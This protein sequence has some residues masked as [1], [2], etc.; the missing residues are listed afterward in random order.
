MSFVNT[1]KIAKNTVLLYVRM[2]LLM[3]VSFYTSRVILATLGVDDYGLYNLIGGIITLFSFISGSLV[4]AMQRYF[5]VALGQHDEAKYHRVYVMG[6]NL[7]ILFSV[8]VLLVGETVGLWFVNNKLNVPEGRETAAFWVYQFSILTMIVHLLKTPDNASIIAHERMGFYAYLSIGEALL[9]LGI[10][11]FLQL[12]E[13]D[14]LILYVILYFAASVLINVAYKVYCNRSFT[15]CHYKWLWDS[16]LSKE[17]LSF[18]GWSL[19]TSGTRTVTMQ[20]ENVFLNQ[21]YSVSVNAARGVASQ[22][23][24]T[25]NTFV[26]NFVIAFRPQLIKSYAAGEMENH[27]SL[28]YRSSKFS[29]YLL[30]V[31]VIPAVFNLDAL[32]GVWLVEVPLYTKEFCIFVLLAYLADALATPLSI[33]IYANGN[34]KGIQISTSVVFVLQLI[35]SFFALKAKWPPYIV[36]VFIFVSHSIHY[37]FYIF[38]CK[39]LC[40][41]HLRKYLIKVVLPLVPVCIISPLLPWFLQ[42]FSVGFWRAFGLCVVDVVWGLLVIWLLGMGKEEKQYVKSIILKMIKRS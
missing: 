26:Q 28:V 6:Y 2:I 32:L 21:N 16:A 18:S 37:L 23:Y 36:S 31:L 19:L 9:K 39:R 5:N 40:H 14:K 7:I 42:K 8:I 20:S 13:I 15:V 29:F 24:N 4:S 12:F 10:V 30:L 22:V 1:K 33:S 38:F 34:I 27:F 17:L 3:A 25:I 41:L 35:A 11:Y